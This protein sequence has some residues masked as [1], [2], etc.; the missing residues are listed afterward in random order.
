MKILRG[1]SQQDLQVTFSQ[2][3]AVESVNMM[4]M[5]GRRLLTVDEAGAKPES[6]NRLGGSRKSG[7]GGR[8]RW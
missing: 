1:E 7:G 3:G 2:F 4:E 8:G 5:Q 6:G